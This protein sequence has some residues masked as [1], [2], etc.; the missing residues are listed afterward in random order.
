MTE[1]L[2]KQGSTED[3]LGYGA[4]ADALWARTVRALDKDQGGK[5]LGDDPLVIGIFGEWGAGKSHL[6]KLVYERAQEQSAR[7]IAARVLNASSKLPLTVTVPVMFQPWKYE[8]EPHLHVPMAIHVA[9]ALDDAWK[10][11]PSDFEKVKVWAERVGK[12]V[13]GVGAKLEAA[14][15]WLNKLGNYWQ[16]TRAFVKSDAAD[17]VAG[18]LDVMATAILVPPVL[19]LGLSKVRE[20]LGDDDADADEAPAPKRPTLRSGSKSSPTAPTAS[21]STVSTS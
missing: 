1:P 11:L 21:R 4:Y 18:T 2:T 6:L 8:H 15:P 7:D 9:D 5:P 16:S 20:R 14:K 10:T 12:N 13:E 19:S 17:V 3:W